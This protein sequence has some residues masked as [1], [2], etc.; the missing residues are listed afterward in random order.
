MQNIIENAVKYGD[1]KKIQL[2]FKFEDNCILVE[3]TNSGCTLSNDEFLHIFDS[4]W[5]GSNVGSNDG[6]G[7]GL[8]IC[9]KLM[10]AMGGEVFAKCYEEEI[11]VTV[12]FRM[13]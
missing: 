12:V 11:C 8:Y 1:G 9:K 10:Q 6:S 2:S 4:F 3:I 5:R 7:L 13:A